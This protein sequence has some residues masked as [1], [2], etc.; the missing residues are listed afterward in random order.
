VSASDVRTSVVIQAPAK[1]NLTL[2]VLGRRTDGYHEIRSILTT[3]SLCDELRVE[4]GHGV[5]ITADPGYDTSG[6]PLAPGEEN[7]VEAALALMVQERAR[8]RGQRVP[9]REVALRAGLG[10][11][12]LT[13][14]K[15]IPAAAGLGGGS[16]DAAAALLALDRLWGLRLAPERLLALAALIGSDCPFLIRGGVQ[17][18][19]G[20]G[21]I[22]EP[23][24][25]PPAATFAFCIV[26]PAIVLQA[27]TARLYALLRTEDFT[28]GRQSDDLARRILRRSS[29]ALPPA[30]LGNVFDRVAAR[31]YGDQSRVRAAL[32]GCGAHAVHLCGAGPAI[33]GLFESRTLAERA[34]GSLSEEGYAAWA[35]TAPYGE[36]TSQ[37]IE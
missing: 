19:R 7:S 35:V 12:A 5:V 18:A 29:A 20:R 36:H 4:N 16:S 22:L 27:K 6:L 33:Y 2:E 26:K 23:L 24:P 21:E 37:L 25:A 28:D 17:Y 3:C 9:Q 8:L 13:L 10:E 30:V 15:R 31:A 14:H 11:V 34:C 32:A 1:L